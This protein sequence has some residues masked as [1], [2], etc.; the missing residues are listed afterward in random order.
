MSTRGWVFYF[1]LSFE[2]WSL[3]LKLANQFE[4]LS[5]WVAKCNICSTS[6]QSKLWLRLKIKANQSISSKSICCLNLFS[7]PSYWWS[8]HLSS[9]FVDDKYHKIWISIS[10]GRCAWFFFC[11]QCGRWEHFSFCILRS[12]RCEAK[13]VKKMRKNCENNESTKVKSKWNRWCMPVNWAAI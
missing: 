5:V 9:S 12:G 7:G 1:L 3:V 6:T 10:S 8:W 13:K 2:R 11:S 4:F